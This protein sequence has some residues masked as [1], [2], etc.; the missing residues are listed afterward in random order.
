ML[1]F[2]LK[3]PPTSLKS[4]AFSLFLIDYCSKD[5]EL[6]EKA[7]FQIYNSQEI[8]LNKINWHYDKFKKVSEGNL[9]NINI[10]E[11]LKA[12]EKPNITLSEKRLNN[13]SL[14]GLISQGKEPNG[15]V[16]DW[17]N[18]IIGNKKFNIFI[19]STVAFALTYKK[20]PIAILGV[21]FEYDSTMFIKQIQGVKKSRGLAPLNWEFFWIDY[22]KEWSINEGL[23]LLKIQGAKN[24]L[25]YNCGI[26]KDKAVRRYDITALRQGFLQDS[27]KNWYK[28]I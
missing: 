9:N 16:K 4:I 27:E 17:G 14:I 19:D 21:D 24:N 2:W 20:L 28:K 7:K 3:I 23:S 13:Y 5:L 18:K 25:W 11:I 8:T 12:Y 6:L 22:A 10:K 1:N 15:Y 26:N